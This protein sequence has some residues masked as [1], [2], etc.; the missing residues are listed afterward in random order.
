MFPEG[1]SRCSWGSF[2]PAPFQKMLCMMGTVGVDGVGA[3]RVGRA[4][5]GAEVE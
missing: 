5:L 3:R 2:I 4:V 1:R